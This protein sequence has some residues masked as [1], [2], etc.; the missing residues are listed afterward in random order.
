[1]LYFRIQASTSTWYLEENYAFF[2]SN[3]LPPPIIVPCCGSRIAANMFVLF[4]V[5]KRHFGAGAF[6]T[7]LAPVDAVFMSPKSLQ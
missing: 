4:S 2:F 7:L 1:M 3:L 5:L 6:L